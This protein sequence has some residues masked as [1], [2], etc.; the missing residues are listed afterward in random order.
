[1]GA[2]E[3]VA[4]PHHVGGVLPLDATERGGRGGAV[5]GPRVGPDRLGGFARICGREQRDRRCR[6]HSR[7]CRG[8]DGHRLAGAPGLADQIEQRAAAAVPPRRRCPVVV[9][10]EQQ[11]SRAVQTGGWVQQRMRQRQDHQRGGC[12]TQQQQPPRHVRRRA[13]GRGQ[14]EQQADGREIDPPRRGRRDL[15]QPPDGGQR[16]EPGEEPGVDEGEG[17]DSQHVGPPG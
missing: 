5:A 3:S 10:H 17:A 12:Q 8:D 15:E 1:M 2:C 6:S 13:F 16:G 11:G 9:D 7:R 4:Q 14:A